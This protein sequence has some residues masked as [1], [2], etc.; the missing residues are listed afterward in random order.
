MIY[1]H[2]YAI[3]NDDSVVKDIIYAK[4]KEQADFIAS[5]S[6]VYGKAFCVDYWPVEINDIYC[7][8]K[9]LRQNSSGNYNEVVPVTDDSEYIESLK[10]LIEQKND[11]IK[12]LENKLNDTSI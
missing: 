5:E 11:A 9:F 1:H 3:L 8:R 7:N 12:Y 6:F 2:V 10:T 4:T